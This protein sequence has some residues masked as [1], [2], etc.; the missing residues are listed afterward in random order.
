MDSNSSFFKH[1]VAND[2]EKNEKAEGTQIY[3]TK[4]LQKEESMRPNLKL[5]NGLL[6]L[7]LLLALPF[8]VFAKGKGTKDSKNAL[9]AEAKAGQKVFNES[10]FACHFDKQA[11]TKVGPSLMGLFKGKEMPVSHKPVTDA[12]VRTQIENGNPNAMPMPMPA[13]GNTL[14]KTD[15]SNVIAYLKTL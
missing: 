1:E 6:I 8:M 7:V 15:I 14:S 9:S 2:V 10:C 12:N 13:F 3:A 5:E 11:G 4:D